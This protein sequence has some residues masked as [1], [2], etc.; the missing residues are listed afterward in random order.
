MPANETVR[1]PWAYPRAI[2]DTDDTLVTAAADTQMFA[3]IIDDPFRPDST[4]NAIEIAFTMKAD[5]EA[6]AAFLFAARENGD[7]VQ[8]WDGTLT[9]GKQEATSG[10]FYVDTLGST[11]DNWITT[12]KEVDVGGADQMSR[13]IL[14]TCGYKY[15]FCQFTGLSSEDVQAMYSGF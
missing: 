4:I 12:I 6:C 3:D 1:K 9:A 10:R 15:F 2:E 8:V 7:I 13:I 5:G 11:T 14:D